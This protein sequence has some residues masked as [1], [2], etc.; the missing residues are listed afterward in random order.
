[1][2]VSAMFKKGGYSP[3]FVNEMSKILQKSVFKYNTLEPA[4]NFQRCADV[5]EFVCYCFNDWFIHFIFSYLMILFITLEL[6]ITFQRWDNVNRF[7]CDGYNDWLIYLFVIFNAFQPA[8]HFLRCTH[9]NGFVWDWFNDWLIYL[10][11]KNL[12]ISMPPSD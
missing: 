3:V 12:M 5:N 9:V 2:V 6:A 10:S 7:V 8:I 11:I 4:I 1:M